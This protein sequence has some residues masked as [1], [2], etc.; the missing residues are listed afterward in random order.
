[1]AGHGARGMMRFARNFRYSV[2]GFKKPDEASGRRRARS[3]GGPEA[4]WAWAAG[5]AWCVARGKE[6]GQKPGTQ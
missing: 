1:M 2:K 4:V 5:V 6:V 3:G